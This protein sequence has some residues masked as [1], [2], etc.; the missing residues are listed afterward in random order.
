VGAAF[1]P[2]HLLLPDQPFAN[3]FIDV[4]S[5]KVDAIRLIQALATGLLTPVTRRK[6]DSDF[7][8]SLSPTYKWSLTRGRILPLA[9]FVDMFYARVVY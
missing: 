2:A 4:G 1:G 6:L 5:T 9:L 8:F 7:E 3:H